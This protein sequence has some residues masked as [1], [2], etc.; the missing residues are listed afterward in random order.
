MKRIFKNNTKKNNL[1]KRINNFICNK[2]ANKKPNETKVIEKEKPKAINTTPDIKRIKQPKEQKTEIKK[3]NSQKQNNPEIKEN[4]SVTENNI[5]IIYIKAKNNNELK[6]GK[7][8]E[9][10]SRKGMEYGDKDIFHKFISKTDQTPLYSLAD[11]KQPG[12]ISLK[13]FQSSSV[14]GVTVFTDLNQKENK[15]AFIHAL[16]TASTIAVSLNCRLL[17][18]KKQNWSSK[19]TIFYLEKI[20]QIQIN[21]KGVANESRK[22]EENIIAN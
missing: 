22:K 12:S 20:K 15:K 14:K 2:I 13:D 4:K 5:C 7:V 10:I 1:L 9:I 16:N 3:I 21:R 11:I 17:N 18:Q 6:L 19:D 8:I